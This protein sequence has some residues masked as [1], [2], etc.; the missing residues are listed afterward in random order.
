MLDYTKVVKPYQCFK[1]SEFNVKIKKCKLN[2]KRDKS[3]DNKI[4]CI[5]CYKILDNLEPDYYGFAPRWIRRRL[6][7]EGL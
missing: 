6:C 3:E 5:K 7:K 2:I 1:C 4:K